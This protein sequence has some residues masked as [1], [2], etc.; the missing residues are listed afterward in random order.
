MNFGE[1]KKRI[2]A[3]N[4]RASR[5]DGEIRITFRDYSKSKAEAV[6][7]YTDDVEDAYDTAV[8]MHK[9]RVRNEVAASESNCRRAIA[10]AKRLAY[11]DAE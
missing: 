7:Y 6:A 4:M 10:A 8:A 3:Y 9:E 2:A 11:G 1:L 5:R